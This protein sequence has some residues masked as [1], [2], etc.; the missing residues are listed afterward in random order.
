MFLALAGAV[1]IIVVTLNT[2]RSEGPGSAGVPVGRPWPSFAAPLAAGPVQGDVNVATR[3]GEG[4]AGARPA[5]QVRGPGI[6]TECV[7]TSGAP[8][9]LAFFATASGRC[10]RELDVLERA[11]RAAP[12]VRVAAVAIRGDRERAV[13]LARDGGWRFPV[14]YDRDG[15][16][17]NL[18]GVAVCPHIAYAL[19]GGRSHGTTIGSLGLAALTARLRRLAADARAAGWRPS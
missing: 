12:G 11:R 4:Q 8:A 9:V 14:A 19:P 15:V 2:L 6:L 5:C 7:F 17:A 16:L 13:T 1:L 18:Y 10:A 3:P